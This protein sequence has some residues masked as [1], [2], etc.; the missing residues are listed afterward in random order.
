M[1]MNYTA[2]ENDTTEWMQEQDSSP[3]QDLWG[4]N[5]IQGYNSDFDV[6]ISCG[7]IKIDMD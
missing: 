5:M 3:I 4:L 2:I 6:D 7:S 1:T